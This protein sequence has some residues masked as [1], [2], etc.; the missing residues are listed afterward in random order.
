MD[1]GRVPEGGQAYAVAAEAGKAG[2]LEVW[3][4]PDRKPS[5]MLTCP[6]AEARLDWVKLLDTVHRLRV[7][8][9][10]EALGVL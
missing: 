7:L 9:P 4:G 3:Q 1:C 5:E 10:T 6:V 2:S 8:G